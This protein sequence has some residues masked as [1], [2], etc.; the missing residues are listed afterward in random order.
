MDKY[1]I[2]SNAVKLANEKK[3][4][5]AKK[6]ISKADKALTTD[7]NEEIESYELLRET[8]TFYVYY[9]QLMKIKK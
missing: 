7:N 4:E 6:E 3:F 1:K 2:L 5:E 8:V 9:E